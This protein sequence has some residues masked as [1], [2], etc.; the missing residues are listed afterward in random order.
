MVLVA[1]LVRAPD[2]GSGGRGFKSHHAPKKAVILMAFFRICFSRILE[3]PT[4]LEILGISGFKSHHAP[5]KVIVLMA[6]FVYV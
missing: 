4:K 2:C 6:F 5:K 3:M 1:Q